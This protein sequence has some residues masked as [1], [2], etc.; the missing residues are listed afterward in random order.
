MAEHRRPIEIPVGGL[1]TPFGRLYRPLPGG[2]QIAVLIGAFFGGPALG[3]IVGRAPGDLSETARTVLHLPYM[4]VFFLGYSIW[5]AR[6]NAI[7]FDCLG[8][9]LLK[10]LFQ[11]IVHR[12]RPRSLEEV[13]PS[14]EKL[15]EMVVRAQRAGASFAPVGWL[16]GVAAGLTAALFESSMSSSG[17]FLM[18]TASCIGWSHLLARLGRRG[19]LP[20]AEEG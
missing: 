6:L 20:F 11:L 17:L 12:R 13:M 19:W 16:V 1:E 15:L 2:W 7:A 18:V 9:S 14:R 10:T 5:V 8:R 4:A 3:W